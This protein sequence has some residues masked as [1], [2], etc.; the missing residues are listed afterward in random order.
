MNIKKLNSLKENKVLKEDDTTL[1]KAVDA[2]LKPD[3]IQGKLEKELDKALRTNLRVQRFGAG[4]Y[5]NILIVGEAGIGKTARVKQWAKK[6]NINLVNLPASTLDPTDLS[7]TITSGEPDEQGRRYA[8][9]LPSTEL[10]DLDKPR[11]VLF[12][13]EFNRARHD[14]R[15][16]LLKL[17][18]EHVIYD[19][20][21]PGHYRYVPNF[22]F[23]IAAINPS[24][25]NYNTDQL[26]A[27]ELS[28]FR[29]VILGYE[30][31]PWLDHFIEEQDSFLQ[32]LDPE[33]P[34]DKKEI[35]AIEGRKKLASTLLNPNNGFTFSSSQEIAAAGNSGS[36]TGQIS[37]P[38]GLTQLLNACDGTKEE[39]L[40]MWPQ[41][42]NRDQ[43]PMIKRI[44]ANYKDIEDKATDVITKRD[45]ES[46]VFNKSSSIRDRLKQVGVLGN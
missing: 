21:V 3:K 11:S 45:T 37:S 30:Y 26:D 2:S 44:F 13:D 36:S 10:N 7:G 28:R 40:D 42:M 12:L 27:A 4:D 15:G 17:I 23:T 22:L 38:R 32:K 29:I 20:N 46:N 1:G 41:S 39:F 16:V 31:Q 6:N 19:S 43:L 18:Q 35:L 8:F 5:D 33:N 14:V 9:R 24:D 25:M 34:E